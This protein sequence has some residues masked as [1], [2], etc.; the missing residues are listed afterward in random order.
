[1]SFITEITMKKTLYIALL[2]VPVMFLGAGNAKSAKSDQT[3][4][5]TFFQG[6]GHCLNYT[7][8][9]APRCGLGNVRFEGNMVD[10]FGLVHGG[11]Q[12]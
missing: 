7:G 4:G 3:D 5:P 8:Q 10:E 11:L 12:R 9:C 1:M 2:T 6:F